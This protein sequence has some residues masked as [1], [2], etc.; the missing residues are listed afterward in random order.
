MDRPYHVFVAGPLGNGDTASLADR[1]R[2]VMRAL[3]AADSLLEHGFV[4]VVPHLS[5]FW[6]RVSPKS[7]DTWLWLSTY[8]MSRCDFVLRLSGMSKGADH[9]IAV[10]HTLDIP[11]VDSIGE[12]IEE[13]ALR[14]AFELS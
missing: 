10:A 6:H 13:V 12:L 2:N 4:P 5:E 8:Q 9:E 14:E 7:Y 11:V 3:E 1:N